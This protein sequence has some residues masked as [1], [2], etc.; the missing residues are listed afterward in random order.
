MIK[1]SPRGKDSA[2]RAVAADR[3]PIIESFGAADR[4]WHDRIIGEQRGLTRQHDEECAGN[5]WRKTV[6]KIR[7]MNTRTALSAATILTAALLARSEAAPERHPLPVHDGF[8]LEADVPC[9]E[10]YTAAMLQIMGDRFESGRQLCTI[11]SVSRQGKSF[12]ATDECQETSMGRKSSGKLT[13]VIPDDHT[14]V[15]GTKDQSMRYR[16]CPIP[17]L[18]ASFKDAHEMVPDTPPF[19]QGR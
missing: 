17:S 3:L 14:V 9:G 13:I 8:Y 4:R 11:K 19:E 5:S 16:Y 12:T 7:T 15:F 1:V 6:R 2:S 18:P 10:A